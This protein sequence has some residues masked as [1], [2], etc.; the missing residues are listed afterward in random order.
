MRSLKAADFI[1]LVQQYYILAGSKFASPVRFMPHW[2]VSELN[3]NVMIFRRRSKHSVLAGKPMFCHQ[4][5]SLSVVS[6]VASFAP[7]PP[8]L[9]VRH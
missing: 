7:A 8:G 3:I 6:V 2:P 9:V 4:S 5:M 1:G